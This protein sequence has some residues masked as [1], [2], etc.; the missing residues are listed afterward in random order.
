MSKSWHKKKLCA[1]VKDRTSN[2]T[3]GGFLDVFDA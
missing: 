2:E 3:L 1:F